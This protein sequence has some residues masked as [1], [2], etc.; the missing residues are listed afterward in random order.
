MPF[1]P[2]TDAPTTTTGHFVPDAAPTPEPAKPKSSLKSFS[3]HPVEN[4]IEAVPEAAAATAS[5]LAGHYGGLLAGAG[6]IPLHAAGIIKTEPQDVRRNVE[7]ALTYKPR[8]QWGQNLAEYNPAAL[9]GK[10][11]DYAGEGLQN[12]IKQVPVPPGF[13]SARDALAAGAREAVGA[14]PMFMGEAAPRAVRGTG[15]AMKAGGERVM[16]SALKPDL[17]SRRLTMP[18]TDMSKAEAGVKTLLEEGVNVTKGGAEKL[19]ERVTD[20]NDRIKTVIENSPARIDKGRAA[21]ALQ[22]V[23]NKFEKQVN[24]TKDLKRIEKAW[25]DFL[26]HPLLS[27]RQTMPIQLAQELK[28]GTYRVLKDKAYGELKGADIEAQKALARGL[29]EEIAAAAPEVRPLNAEESKLLNALSLVERRVL[30]EANR[31]PIGLGWLSQN[32]KQFAGWMADRSDL[33]KSLVARMLYQTGEATRGAAP[34]AGP[35]MGLTMA[36]G[37]EERNRVIPPIPPQ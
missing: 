13:R 17:P 10:G 4:V 29:K 5:G 21:S 9:V 25:D 24:S 8:T 16:Q 11:L 14:A 12:K 31:N 23:V 34:V 19:H 27:G 7:S 22:D 2:D 32:A 6:S 33:F 3:E 36:H 15:E 37:A 28:Q 26:N 35:G 30:Q 18:G 20:L 1:V